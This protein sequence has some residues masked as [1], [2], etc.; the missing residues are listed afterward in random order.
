[1]VLGCFRQI[2]Q[3][4]APTL[5][6]PNDIGQVPILVIN[7]FIHT[8]KR[9]SRVINLL[10]SPGHTQANKVQNLVFLSGFTKKLLKLSQ[11]DHYFFSLKQT[12]M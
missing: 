10:R 8:K 1:M 11:I 7:L 2:F 3:E 12:T 6:L 5:L 4:F 9:H